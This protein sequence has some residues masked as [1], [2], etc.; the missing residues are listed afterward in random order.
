MASPQIPKRY[1]LRS[2]T[3]WAQLRLNLFTRWSVAWRKG[4][5]GD[6]G[7]QVRTFGGLATSMANLQSCQSQR[8]GVAPGR[9]VHEVRGPCPLCPPLRDHPGYCCCSW[10]DSQN[11]TLPP[12]CGNLT[13]G[14]IRVDS[15]GKFVN[16]IAQ[17]TTGPALPRLRKTTD[18]QVHRLQEHIRSP[19]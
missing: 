14:C 12:L 16:R 15:C 10:R 18:L 9:V 17:G 4:T 6:R 1:R 5:S 7:F 8:H 3:P 19:H 13:S 2:A 11:A